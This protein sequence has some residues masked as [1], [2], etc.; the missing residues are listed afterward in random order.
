MEAGVWVVS[1][2]LREDSYSQETRVI[3]MPSLLSNSGSSLKW[4][5]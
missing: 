4:R 3:L 5:P 1:A 2:Q